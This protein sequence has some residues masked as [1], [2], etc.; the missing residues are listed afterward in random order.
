MKLNK[1]QLEK[2]TQ[3]TMQSVRNLEHNGIIYAVFI[4]N[5]FRK[6]GW[7]AEIQG[8]FYVQL[9]KMKLEQKDDIIDFYLTTDKNA[10]DSIDAICLNSK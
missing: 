8:E 2:F 1:K 5:R 3:K 10:K 4:T 7:M 9:A 6:I